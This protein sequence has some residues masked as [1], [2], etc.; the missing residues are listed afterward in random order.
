MP[1]GNCFVL[2][3]TED[4]HDTILNPNID[5]KHQTKLTKSKYCPN[6]SLDKTIDEN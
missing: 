3:N 2:N 5:T 4:N 6:K 1:L